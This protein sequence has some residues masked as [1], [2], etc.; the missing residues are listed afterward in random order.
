MPA[1]TI[2]YPRN[3]F[4]GDEKGEFKRA[5]KLSVATYM[6]AVDPV[7]GKRTKYY[8]DP[9]SFIDLVLIPYDFTDVEATALCLATIV[10]YDWPDRMAD[11]GARLQAITEEVRRFVPTDLITAGQDRISFTFIGKQPGCWVAR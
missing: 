6:D 2:N 11:I 8:D 7:S 9:D 1:V 10:S 4:E 3:L 5:V